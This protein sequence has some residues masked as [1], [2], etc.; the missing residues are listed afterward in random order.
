MTLIWEE[1]TIDNGLCN[2]TG[3]FARRAA[4]AHFASELTEM[5]AGAG[6]GGDG[7]EE[8]AADEQVYSQERLLRRLA[9]LVVG[10]LSGNSV[11][12]DADDATFERSGLR[13]RRRRDVV[14]ED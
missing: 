3:K 4:V 7:N 5:G 13:Q 6:S 12:A 2:P 10:E 9:I 1:F 14:H 8:G 11:A